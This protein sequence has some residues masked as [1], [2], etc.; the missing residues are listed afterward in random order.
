VIEAA[1]ARGAAGDPVSVFAAVRGWK[2]N[3]K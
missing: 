3:Y 1:R 2:D